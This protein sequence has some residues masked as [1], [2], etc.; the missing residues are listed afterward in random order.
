M[1]LLL[2]GRFDAAERQRWRDELQRA[3]PQAEWLD[4]EDAHRVADEI[5]G[6]VVAN[7]E[8]GSLQ[9]L[10]R[11]RLI[12]SLWAGVDRLLADTS[13]PPGIPIVRMVDPAMTAAMTETALWAVLALHRGFYA[14]AR[15]QARAE[16]RQHHQ[17]RA[18]E[19]S[20]VVLGY[21]EMG[22]AVAQRL[23]A[24]GYP[25][26]AWRRSGGEERDAA[27]SVVGGEDALPALLAGSEILINLLPLAPATR[28]LLDARL[29]AALPR[30]AAVVNLGRGAHV[31]DADLLEALDSGHLREAVL[32]VFHTEPLPT[33]H[34]F[35]THPRVTLLPHAAALTDPRSAAQVVAANVA[36][37]QRGEPVHPLVQRARGY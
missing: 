18:D 20:L 27:V 7:P 22:R 21:G 32:D 35:W 29:F 24:N 28:A 16:W 14:Y 4:V 36:A 13:I 19:V 34:P 31:V 9:G 10:P 6:A 12:H 33:Q 30:G 1:K 17:R 11:L 37:W 3:L 2:A 25:V 26:S 15:R 23:A 5:E 8:P